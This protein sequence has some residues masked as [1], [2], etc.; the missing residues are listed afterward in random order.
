MSD[1]SP[2]AAPAA[3]VARP[4][5]SVMIPTYE[6]QPHFLRQAVASVL[7]QDPGPEAMEIVLVDDCSQRVDP[8]T[9]LD[10]GAAKR[11]G[12]VRQAGHV[13][14]GA[15]GYTCCIRTIS[16][17]RAFTHAC[18]PGSRR[19]RPP[20]PPSVATWSSTATTAASPTNA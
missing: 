8:R 16:C 11:V 9:A 12:W 18:A 6:P 2:I 19:R 14:I 15:N 10:G 13:G 4:F 1:H 20:A 5:W 17:A 7:D 3:N